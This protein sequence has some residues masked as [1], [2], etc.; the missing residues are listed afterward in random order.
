MFERRVLLLCQC[1][2][3]SVCRQCCCK[4]V[5]M[6]AGTLQ[7]QQQQQQQHCGACVDDMMVCALS[8]MRSSTSLLVTLLIVAATCCTTVVDAENLY[9]VIAEHRGHTGGM[10]APQYACETY[11][12]CI[13]RLQ[14][15]GCIS[16]HLEA[17]HVVP[18]YVRC[19]LSCVLHA[20]RG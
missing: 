1:T 11:M 10:H 14:H 3:C 6:C 9:D 8:A 13:A 18:V 15:R 7:R 19:M 5:D 17:L 16:M 12:C 2:D 4:D 20:A